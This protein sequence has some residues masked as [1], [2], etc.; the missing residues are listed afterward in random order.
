MYNFIL[1]VK[2]KQAGGGIP[3]SDSSHKQQF[4]SLLNSLPIIT[5]TAPGLLSLNLTLIETQPIDSCACRWHSPN[6][7]T[8]LVFSC[9]KMSCKLDLLQCQQAW[10][11]GPWGTCA[12]KRLHARVHCA[13]PTVWYWTERLWFEDHRHWSTQ[14][15]NVIP[16]RVNWDTVTKAVCQCKWAAGFF[17][18]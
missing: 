2:K 16:Q 1:L 5:W 17:E 7:C 4:I 13:K 10:A 14:C 11:R 12:F 18:N 3:I 6:C 9:C 15:L 8:G